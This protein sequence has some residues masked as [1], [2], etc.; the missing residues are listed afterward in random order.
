MN[1][2]LDVVDV[3]RAIAYYRD[4]FGLVPTWMWEENVGG[5]TTEVEPVELYFSRAGTPVP[6]RLAVF[7]D[8]AD[9]AYAKYRAAGAEI[10]D[11]V[12]TKP[13]GLRGFTVKD[14]DGNLIGISHEVHG[15]EHEA[16]YRDLTEHQQPAQRATT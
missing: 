7:V 1:P 10:V 15:P 2:I 14:P 16:R 5:V 6:S 9:R 13:W 3:S 8:D 11:K 4:V 12:E